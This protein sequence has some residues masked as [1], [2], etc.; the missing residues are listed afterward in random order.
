MSYTGSDTRIME[1]RRITDGII[2]SRPTYYLPLP[3]HRANQNE[4]TFFLLFSFSPP[5]FLRFTGPLRASLFF[6]LSY[7]LEPLFSPFLF[8]ALSFLHEKIRDR[9]LSVVRIAICYSYLLLIG[10][11]VETTSRLGWRV[12]LY[13]L[14]FRQ[15]AFRNRKI[16]Y[17]SRAAIYRRVRLNRTTERDSRISNRKTLCEIASHSLR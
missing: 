14:P 11:R 12:G 17:T 3:I 6:S 8:A 1:R 5:P 9:R 4:S 10:E 16:S 7:F 2:S 13:L 15:I